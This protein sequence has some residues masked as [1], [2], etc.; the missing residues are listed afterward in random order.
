[1][2]N[3][4]FLGVPILKHIRVF[5]DPSLEP[6]YRDGSNERSQH[7]FFFFFFL[8]RNKKKIIFELS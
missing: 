8:L 7:I 5:R 1:M 4:L 3:L 2:E 6:S